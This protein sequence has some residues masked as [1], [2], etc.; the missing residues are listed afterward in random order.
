MGLPCLRRD[1]V[2]SCSLPFGCLVAILYWPSGVVWICLGGVVEA[3]AE[4]WGSPIGR[5]CCWAGGWSD[6]GEMLW[7][8]VLRSIWPVSGYLA[9]GCRWK[10]VCVLVGLVC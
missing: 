10:G 7:S 8:I 9:S 5:A 6:G 2:T 1:T 3:G 4:L